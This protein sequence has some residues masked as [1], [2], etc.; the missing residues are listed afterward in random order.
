MVCFSAD[1]DAVALISFQPR[2]KGGITALAAVLYGS[3]KDVS[4][5][6]ES[7]WNNHKEGLSY[8]EYRQALIL[9]KLFEYQSL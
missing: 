2:R 9:P 5:S 6:A 3:P 8:Q 7:L 1:E 4:V